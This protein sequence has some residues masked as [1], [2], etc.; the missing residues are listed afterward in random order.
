MG[1]GDALFTV[2]FSNYVDVGLDCFATSFMACDKTLFSVVVYTVLNM[3]A[4]TRPS[5]K[6]QQ[7]S[8]CKK[9]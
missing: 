7:S 8:G 4:Q 2:K 6:R 9:Q 5:V 1:F 3:P